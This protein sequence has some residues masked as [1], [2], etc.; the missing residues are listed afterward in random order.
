MTNNPQNNP[1]HKDCLDEVEKSVEEFKNRFSTKTLPDGF[2]VVNHHLEDQQDWLRNKLTTLNQE[3]YLRG[4][5]QG[6]FDAEMDK[7]LPPTTN[8]K[9]QL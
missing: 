1:A 7:E 8:N 4:Y 9:N 5:K 3:A 2:V 6:K